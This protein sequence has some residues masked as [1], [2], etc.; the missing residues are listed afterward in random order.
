MTLEQ[1]GAKEGYCIHC[2]DPNLR[3]K[4]G[5]FEDVSKVE[6]YTIS[7]ADYDKREDSFRNFK[8]RQ[9][10]LNPNFKSYAG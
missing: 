2:I 6:K 7:D 9:L 3:N 4:Q 1:Y 5:E 10:A 8:K